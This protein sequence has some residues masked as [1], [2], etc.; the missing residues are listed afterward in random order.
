MSQAKSATTT[1]TFWVRAVVHG[2]FGSFSA[3][4]AFGPGR[5]PSTTFAPVGTSGW[6]FSSR[7][8]AEELAEY[9]AKR[10]YPGLSHECSVATEVVQEN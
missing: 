5:L 1:S 9:A 8:H 4:V 7:A 2:P 3:K 6:N 10:V